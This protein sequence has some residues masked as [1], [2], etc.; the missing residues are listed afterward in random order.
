MRNQLTSFSLILTM[1]RT[2]PALSNG[3]V[4]VFQD[5]LFVGETCD[6]DADLATAGM[7]EG[8][9]GPAMTARPVPHSHSHLTWT[10]LSSTEDSKHELECVP[11]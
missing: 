5:S 2:I 7:I 3:G 9:D 11:Q 10:S 4:H 8:G 1:D 6:T